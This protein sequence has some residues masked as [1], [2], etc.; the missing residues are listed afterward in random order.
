MAYA[1]NSP[2]VYAKGTMD[3][4]LFNPATFSLDFYSNKVQTNSLT[5]STNMGEINGSLRNPVL[6]NLPDSAKLEL[7]ITAATSTLESRALSVGGEL[8]YNGIIPVLE[9]V[10]ASGADLAVSQ[11]PAA[12]YGTDTVYGFVD[13][14]G[15]AYEIDADTR[16]VK[17]FT[18]TAGET[19]C[20]RYFVKAASAHQLRIDSVFEPN[21]DICM[22]RM[23]LYTTQGQGN[24]QGTKWGDRYIWIPRMQFKGEAPVKGDQT[25][26]DVDTL[27]GSALP[28]E[29][30]AAEGVCVDEA[31]FA[32]A[33]MVDMPASGVFTDV[34]GIAI[35]GG[36]ISMRVG[37]TKTIPLKYVM[38]DGSLVQPDYGI[39][40]YEIEPKEVLDYNTVDLYNNGQFIAVGEGEG[41]IV[42]TMLV[43]TGER[44]T[45]ET[46]VFVT[47]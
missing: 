14:S 46:N 21:I 33:Y 22:I 38:R 32:L 31:S 27:S 35:V 13:K 23:P 20:V 24:T 1:T 36:D 4:W 5:T 6:L 2:P 40:E 41:H 30:A 17:N 8:T 16:K 42:V 43:D 47:E 29:E 25:D 39:M 3:V 15:I 19:Y 12:P 18:A 26:A 44:Y 10:T 7:E 45:A 37:E 9:T 11:T 28:Y 34:V